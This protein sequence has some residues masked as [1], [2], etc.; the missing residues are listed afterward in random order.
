MVLRLADIVHCKELRKGDGIRWLRECRVRDVW[1]L[2][3]SRVQSK[4]VRGRCILVVPIPCDSHRCVLA[5]GQGDHVAGNDQM[6]IGRG[7]SVAFINQG[8]VQPETMSPVNRHARTRCQP[9]QCNALLFRVI[10]FHFNPRN[11][12]A[13]EF[14]LSLSKCVFNCL[15]PSV[16]DGVCMFI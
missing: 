14:K 3:D 12:R 16:R 1:R 6:R 2:R 13:G 4:A 11:V 8:I 15:V 9:L 7:E 10:R 5:R